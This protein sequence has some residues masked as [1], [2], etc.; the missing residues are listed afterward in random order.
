M[1]IPGFVIS[2]VTF[3]GVIVHEFAHEVF[4]RLTG[5]EV[6]E[7]CY[8]RLG[9]PA[10]YVI[11][12]PASTI[13][14]HILI[15]V[16]PF[17]GNSLLGFSIGLLASRDVLQTGRLTTIGTLLTWLGVSIAMHSFPSTGDAK[18]MWATIWQKGTPITAKVVGIPLVALIVVGAI[19]SIF[20]L[21]LVYGVAIVW[22]LPKL[23][24][25]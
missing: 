11:H 18:S 14:K 6:I 4:C 21:D 5:T 20:W 8:F 9:N 1:V 7:V 15:G 10:G 16:G 24:L 22:G 25:G 2:I 12:A 17:V 19:G 3:P 23:L 13:W